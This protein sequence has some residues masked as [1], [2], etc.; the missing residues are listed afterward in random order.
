MHILVIC[1][2]FQ[3]V[4]HDCKVIYKNSTKSTKVTPLLNSTG[5]R[6]EK[7]EKHMTQTSFRNKL[8]GLPYINRTI[9]SPVEFHTMGAGNN[10]VPQ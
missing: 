5:K 4:L 10:R 1:Q 7:K 2:S 6:K 9:R 3:K 8:K